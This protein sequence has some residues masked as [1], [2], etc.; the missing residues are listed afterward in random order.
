M[1]QS[2]ANKEQELPTDQPMDVNFKFVW[3]SLILQSEE[4]QRLATWEMH[5]LL[6][7]FYLFFFFVSEVHKLTVE[8]SRIQQGD[9]VES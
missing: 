6:E 8:R 1:N 7:F 3:N 5:V 4:R 9:T 2:S